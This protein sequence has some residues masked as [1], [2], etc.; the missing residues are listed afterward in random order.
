MESGHW[1]QS[2]TEELDW[3]GG[4]LEDDGIEYEDVVRDVG[5]QDYLLKTMG[6]NFR[7]RHTEELCK[8]SRVDLEKIRH[9]KYLHE[10][11]R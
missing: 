1:F 7:C 2:A 3:D 6:A 4:L 5:R 10:F 11:D 9:I 8:N